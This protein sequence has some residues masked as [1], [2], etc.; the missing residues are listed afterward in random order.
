MTGT[1]RLLNCLKC[2]LFS[3]VF[4]LLLSNIVNAQVFDDFS[5]GNFTQNPP[6]S[7]DTAD[8]KI[9]ASSAIPPEMKPALQ[10][11]AS[12]VGVSFMSVQNAMIN[13]T[14]W[15]FWVKLSFNT[16][17]NNFARVY[18]VSD[19]PNLEGNLSGY[20]VQIGGTND[21]IGLY[22]QQ[23]AEVIK[24][25]SGSNAYTGNSTNE[26]RIKVTRDPA[27]N[28]ELFADD[29]G[30][31]NFQ[32]EG[33]ASDNTFQ[34]TSFFGFV[35]NYTSSNSTKF[36]FDDFYVDEI[37]IDTIPPQ[38]LQI[39]LVD[40]SLIRAVFDEPLEIISAENTMNYLVNP[41]SI[42]PGAAQR[43]P[44]DLNKVLLTFANGFE[45]GEEYALIAS[46][47]GD[48]AGNILTTSTLNF[49]YPEVEGATPFSILINE[50]MADEDPAPAG[51][52][53]ADYL[54]LY[55]TNPFPVNLLNYTL[56]PRESADPAAFPDITIYPDSFL[57]VVAN[58]NMDLFTGFG[59]VTGLSGFSLNNEGTA[60]LRNPDGTL[61]HS[62]NYTKDW[63]RDEEKEE[64]G[65]SIEQ[66]DPMHPCS[67]MFN[68]KASIAQAGGT[69]G[70]RNSM[71]GLT[72][73][74]PTIDSVIAVNENTI[75]LSFGQ[76]MDSLSVT[77][78]SAYELSDGFGNP[79]TCTTSEILF[80]KVDL[81]FNE[82]FEKNKV[83]QLTIT[84]TLLDCSGDMILP[85]EVFEFV[86]PLEPNPFEIV[87]NEIMADP[88][89]PVDLPPYEYIE[90]YNTTSN[91][92][93]VKGWSLEVGS[94]RKSI[95]DF[96]ME[97]DSYMIFTETEAEQLFDSLGNTLT[98]SSLGL[99]NS[100]TTISLLNSGDRIMSVVSYDPSWYTDDMKAEGG[101]SLEQ[102]DPYNPCAGA[103]N[104][105]ESESTT[106]GTPGQINSVDA[107]NAVAPVIDKIIGLDAQ[108]FEVY[109]SQV[110]DRNSVSTTSTYHVDRGIGNPDSVT[111]NDSIY[112]TVILHFAQQLLKGLVY[113]LNME[114]PVL[115]C[116]GI[117]MESNF[118]TLFGIHES[119]GYE[120]VVINEVLF[121]P[122]GSGVDFVELYNRSEKI[123][124]LGDFLLGEKDVDEFGLADSTYK[125]V[126]E[127]D[128]LLFPG[129]Y[130]VL[131][132]NPQKVLDQYYSPNPN[133]FTRMASFPG[134][135]NGSGT[136]LLADKSEKIIDA[137]DYSEDMQ[138]P[139]LNTVE[140]VSLE[141]I[142]Y[143]RP[144][145]DVTNWHSAASEVGYATPAYKNSQ[146]NETTGT[147]GEVWLDPEVFSPDNDGYQDVLNI[148]YKFETNGTSAS[149]SIYDSQGRMVRQLLNNKLLGM[150]GTFS[151]DGRTDD[152]Q[153][154]SVG[155]Y[156]VFF[157]AFDLNGNVKKFKKT[158]VVGG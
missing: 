14:E 86:L 135:S 26:L 55:N 127:D 18:L 68:W 32:P 20:F 93:G 17:A 83:Y 35:C 152:N 5:D 100:G 1:P 108:T 46:N 120:D 64:G 145:K 109:F 48:L 107:D 117:A 151:W 58:S 125:S 115:N 126:M 124:S 106:G 114:L 62:V 91:Y 122:A 22:R 150:E 94:S 99:S 51:L 110:M 39:E 47:I 77:N 89:P 129:Q 28:W 112:R 104:W 37:V 66:I 59:Q 73:F 92:L 103:E 45:P 52:P 137:F 158:A 12:D 97:P 6:W 8:F 138:Y 43:D 80:N 50:I 81:I 157:E 63:Y 95:P 98:F 24:V 74:Y 102:I 2:A 41:G 136:V 78:T 113:T 40:E 147:G 88:E 30:G 156:I 57:I 42:H 144:A 25:L 38:L 4:L 153:R 116:S 85:G 96:M 44:V 11:D 56:K 10:L 33:A 23:G 3:F 49:I 155:I 34:L 16:S 146:F 133:G 132:T 9:S 60:V 75:H 140:G 119:P 149:I 72:A 21:S 31:Y 142:N 123:I 131:T 154:V 69:P 134:Y 76:N 121:N 53:E 27:G 71:D 101:W 7:G 84:D 141:R 128:F 13:N 143:D 70:S 130:R 67:G 139:L 111:L 54:E 79:Q 118:S 65:W 61:M 82:S 105:K 148:N 19:Q 90:L 15:R 29:S 36:Y 87:I